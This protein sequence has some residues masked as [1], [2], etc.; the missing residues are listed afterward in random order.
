[1]KSS[2]IGGQAVIE[3]VMM[4]NKSEYAVAVRK[5]DN[6]IEI[7]QN[8]YVSLNERIGLFRLPVFRGV[9]SF[10][11][12]LVLGMKTLSYS[13]SFYEDETD[14]SK[15]KNNAETADK[16]KEWVDPTESANESDSKR[17]SIDARRKAARD[18]RDKKEAVTTG[19]TMVISV[20]IAVAIFVLLPFL[21]AELFKDKIDSFA[22]RSLIEGV[23]RLV[24]FIA[25]IKLITLMKDIK[26]VFMYHGA[27]HKVINCVEHGQELNVENARKQSKE[28]KRC[29][30]S[31]LL[32]VVIISII[33]FVFIQV[34][35]VWL[36][37]LLRIVLVPVIAGV[38]YEFIRLAG[39]T[40]NIIINILSKPG[41]WLQALTTREPDDSMLEVAIAS[42]NA[43]FDWKSYQSGVK[44]KSRYTS[45]N[46]YDVTE[47]VV[48]NSSSDNVTKNNDSSSVFDA[49]EE[50][51]SEDEDEDDEILKALDKFFVFDKD[52]KDKP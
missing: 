51:P 31:F 29:G 13:A 41:L 36:R 6:E 37:M 26:R 49:F 44:H 16:G 46:D 2:G 5:P 9:A 28:H 32:Y 17:N 33:F 10:I 48:D 27:E 4:K 30:T 15:K 23:I 8:I 21:L 18:K 19:I 40:D 3:G 50:I 38:A 20:I 25:Y 45:D 24:L 1:M 7:S 35:Q 52:E 11:D 47:D 43:V 34:E 39:R 14:S 42:V 22:I 12:S